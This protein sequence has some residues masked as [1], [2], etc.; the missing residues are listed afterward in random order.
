M[1]SFFAK[2]KAFVFW[3]SF[4]FVFTS[5][6]N[7]KDNVQNIALQQDIDIALR[8]VEDAD[9]VF[10]PQNQTLKIIP[11]GEQLSEFDIQRMLKPLYDKSGSFGY[12]Y[13]QLGT[14]TMSAQG[15]N[16]SH[17]LVN[18]Y[19]EG[20]KPFDV[21]NVMMP[22][23]VLSQRKTYMLDSTQYLGREEVWQSSRQAFLYPRGDCEDHSLALA[24]WLI[25]MGEDARVVLGDVD[26]NGHAWVVLFKDGKEY[27]LEAT[28]KRGIS[29]NKP[30]PLA[31]LHRN[32][33]PTF[34]FNRDGFWSNTGTKYT[35]D[36][37]GV[38]WQKMS[39]YRQASTF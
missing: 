35:T 17:F 13:D 19:L 24:D 7:L 14:V 6:I 12:S 27:L 9:Y 4:L 37:A 20:Y 16:R 31:Q 22:L 3:I 30:Y 26:G 36:Y 33:H 11:T 23:Y 1:N 34:M 5:L 21:D 8:D 29:P 18:A 2:L 28:Q 32:Y 38:H 39:H 25:E 15:V 10:S